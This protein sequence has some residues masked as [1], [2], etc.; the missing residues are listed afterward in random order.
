MTGF[1]E[2]RGN[3]ADAITGERLMPGARAFDTG[4]KNR[5]VPYISNQR[6]RMLKEETIVWLAEQAGYD[7]VKRDARNSGNTE[8]VDG[9]DASVGGGEASS[10][11]AK[12][13]R[14]PAAKRRASGTTKSK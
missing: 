13:G 7:V 3:G 10:G 14:K 2:I 4:V 6:T 9:T 1:V 11:K 5:K 12:T 8:V